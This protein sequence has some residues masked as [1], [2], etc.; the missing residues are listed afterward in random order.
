MPLGTTTVAGQS[1]G[2][3]SS[4]GTMLSTRPPARTARS[5]ATLVAGLPQPLTSQFIG[6][7]LCRARLRKEIV[8]NQ[9]EADELGF[10]LD[11]ED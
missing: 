1:D 4:D 11:G 7:L 6:G 5:A 3:I 8:G 10:S 9:D 2:G